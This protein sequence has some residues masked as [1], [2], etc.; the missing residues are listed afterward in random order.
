MGIV[1]LRSLASSMSMVRSQ[2]FISGVARVALRNA[3]YKSG[4]RTF[5]PSIVGNRA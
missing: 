3:P 1:K 4:D 2:R 5:T